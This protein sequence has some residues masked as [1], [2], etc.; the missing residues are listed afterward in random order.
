MRGQFQWKHSL[1]T[2]TMTSIFQVVR[3]QNVSAT[4]SA[5]ESTSE[6]IVVRPVLLIFVVSIA[7][8]LVWKVRRRIRPFS[9]RIVDIQAYNKVYCTKILIE[10]VVE[11]DLALRYVHQMSKN[12]AEID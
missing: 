12:D 9:A 7:I 5:K 2:S 6:W 10:A 8:V 3:A 11:S 1:L 4:H